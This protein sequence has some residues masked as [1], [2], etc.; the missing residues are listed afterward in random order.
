MA[1]ISGLLIV[2]R[3]SNQMAEASKFKFVCAVCG[4]LTIKVTHPEH[5][6]PTTLVECARCDSPRGTI[7]A[8]HELASRGRSELYEF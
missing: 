2:S 1:L 6:A 5:A 4:S 3:L 8:L 7:A